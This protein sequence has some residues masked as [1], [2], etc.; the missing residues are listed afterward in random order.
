MGN[1]ADGLQTVNNIGH[2]GSFQPTAADAWE[3]TTCGFCG[4]VSLFT[5]ARVKQDSRSASAPVSWMRCPRCLRGSVMNDGTP[6]P[7]PLPFSTPEGVPPQEA[8]LWEQVRAS[9]SVGAYSGAAMICRKLLLHVA[10]T[11]QRAADPD[12]KPFRNF[13][14]AIQYLEDEHVI[15]ASHKSWVDQIRQL[16]NRA[17]HE[18]PHI[19]ADE[20]TNIATF[21]FQLFINLYE[22]PFK[23]KLSNPLTG[24]AANPYETPEDDHA[25]S[26]S[27]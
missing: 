12:A 14:K 26:P 18:L 10:Y 3:D 6:S 11:H 17:N 13:A 2:G 4:A 16:G 9:L 23:A 24:E 22:M 1:V 7:S 8:A 20:A 27:E 25:A 21:T 19:E 15:L 5:V